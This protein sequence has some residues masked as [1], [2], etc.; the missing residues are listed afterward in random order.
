MLLRNFLQHFFGKINGRYGNLV[1]RPQRNMTPLP[2][3]PNVEWIINCHSDTPKP[4]LILFL[5]H[6]KIRGVLIFIDVFTPCDRHLSKIIA[7]IMWYHLK[8]IFLHLY[9]TW[10]VVLCVPVGT[11]ALARCLTFFSFKHF[12]N[13]YLLSS[14]SSLSHDLITISHLYEKPENISSEASIEHAAL[15]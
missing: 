1:K 14:Y 10:C 5:K 13:L 3:L 4:W 2:H 12:Q 9:L 7:E 8:S 11:G 15:K 6:H